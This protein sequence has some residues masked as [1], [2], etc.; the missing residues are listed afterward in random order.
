MYIAIQNM[1]LQEIARGTKFHI[2]CNA[3]YHDD[4]TAFLVIQ[5]HYIDSSW[6]LVHYYLNYEVISYPITPQGISEVI[7][8]TLQD[9]NLVEH[10]ISLLLDDHLL[11]FFPGHNANEVISNTLRKAVLSSN[12]IGQKAIDEMIINKAM[13]GSLLE[14]L[15]KGCYAAIEEPIIYKLRTILHF[16]ILHESKF[17]EHVDTMLSADVSIPL[18]PLYYPYYAPYCTLLTYLFDMIYTIGEAIGSSSSR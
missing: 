15:I 9:F 1:L 7:M 8:K 18:Y 5:I 2:A 16:Y 3:V 12:S 13:I 11:S 14:E 17:E 6:T 10:V 4:N